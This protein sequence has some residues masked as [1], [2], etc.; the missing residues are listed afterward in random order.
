MYATGATTF[1]SRWKGR[2][3]ESKSYRGNALGSPELRRPGEALVPASRGVGSGTRRATCNCVNDPALSPNGSSTRVAAHE[4]GRVRVTTGPVFSVIIPTYARPEKLRACLEGIDRLDYERA[5]F[6]VVL[7][8]DGSPQPLEALCAG[9]G[10]RMALRVVTQSRAGPAAARNAGAAVARGRYFAFIDDDCVPAKD[11]LSVFTNEFAKD[12]R[13]LLGGRVENALS[14][15]PY[16]DASDRISSF[17]YEYNRSTRANEP[18]FTTNNIAVAADLFRSLGGFATTIPSATAEDKEFCDRW[19]ERG[20]PLAHVA[21]AI[22]YHAH[23]LTF[24]RFLRQHFN[25]GR[26]ILAFRL[27]RRARTRSRIVPEPVSFYLNLVLSPIRQPAAK[28]RWHAFV[29]VLAAQ[30]ATIAGALR[31]AIAG[32]FRAG[33]RAE[34]ETH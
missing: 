5:D 16:A 34:R 3:W 14:R 13:R 11:W 27:I 1:E 30:L 12:E 7:V 26:G 28:P 8:D 10:D 19:C 23:D 17:V 21:H 24:K 25:Y 31:E 6:E 18:F 4:V 29:L 22:V 32:R 9:F 2:S 15:N 20:L 33:A